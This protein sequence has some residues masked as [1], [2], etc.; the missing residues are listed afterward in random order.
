MLS[1]HRFPFCNSFLV[2]FSDF[3]R[4][5]SLSS[6]LF[7]IKLATSPDLTNLMGFMAANK[8]FGK[9]GENRFSGWAKICL[10]FGSVK[11]QH[12]LSQLFYLSQNLHVA[13]GIF[14]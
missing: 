5:P 4:E 6:P 14:V 9:S 3:L 2:L 13:T 8:N 10:V 12:S 11:H 1:L 7:C